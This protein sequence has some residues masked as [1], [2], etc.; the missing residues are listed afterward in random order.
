ML[1]V[2]HHQKELQVYMR[3][4]YQ[5][6]G[7]GDLILGINWS[8]WSLFW[9]SYKSR[10]VCTIIT[11]VFAFVHHITLWSV[12]ACLCGIS[13]NLYLL[14]TKPLRYHTIVT[15]KRFYVTVA[16]TLAVTILAGGIYL[17]IPNLPTMD[18]KIERCLRNE[19][20]TTQSWASFI[21][22]LYVVIPVCATM[23]FT[24]TIY[25]RLLLIARQKMKN[26]PGI[27]ENHSRKQ[28][29]DEDAGVVRKLNVHV[30]RRRRKMY[31]KGF[32]TILLMT[33]LFCFVW[34]PRLI[35]WV[36]KPMNNFKF[37]MISSSSTWVQPILYLLTNAEARKMCLQ[38]FR[39][40][41]VGVSLLR[42]I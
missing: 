42:Q 3:V 34:T 26:Y 41:R 20:G 5:C 21:N 39:R 33:S 40:N 2:I 9:F 23:A 14:V 1:G 10:E 19:F 25:T 22:M 13:T 4:L 38:F 29:N 8:L 28:A 17:P 36:V 24:T 37:D 18:I 30:A 16:S 32:F 31:P 27:S 7:A 12:M 11:M 15:R 35:S 6:L